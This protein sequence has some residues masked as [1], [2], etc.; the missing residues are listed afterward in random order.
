[1]KSIEQ[2][3]ADRNK[4]RQESRDLFYSEQKCAYQLDRKPWSMI[5]D[6]SSMWADKQI[7]KK[8]PD[9]Q[10]KHL[11]QRSVSPVSHRETGDGRGKREETD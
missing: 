8:K 2:L 3:V 5:P 6:A 11:A 1:V 10:T 9:P 7:F 4:K